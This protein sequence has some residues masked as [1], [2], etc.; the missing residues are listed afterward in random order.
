MTARKLSASPLRCWPHH[1]DLATL[2]TLTARDPAGYIGVGISPGDDYYDEP[3]LYVS[4]YPKP[5][6]ATLPALPAPGHWHLRDFTGAVATAGR[7]VAA[8]D[9]QAATDDFLR[10][11]V[12]GALKILL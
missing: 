6:P 1:F 8:K 11:A 7:I 9:P 12:D 10:A 5:D 2:T 3:Y 4:V